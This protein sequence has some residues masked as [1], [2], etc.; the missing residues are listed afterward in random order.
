MV[1]GVPEPNQVYAAH[2][3]DLRIQAMGFNYAQNPDST[4][5]Y[6]QG[7]MSSPAPYAHSV[8]LG[9]DQ[10]LVQTNTFA[11]NMHPGYQGQPPVVNAYP[12]LQTDQYF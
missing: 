4:S 9:D 2:E 12:H 11:M 3:R 10:M 5:G 7:V 1:T 6:G 8:L